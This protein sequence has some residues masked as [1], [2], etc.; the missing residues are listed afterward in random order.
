MNSELFSSFN[1]FKLFLKKKLRKLHI[2][3]FV[4][5]KTK[6][7]CTKN[8][9]WADKLAK[10]INHFAVTK[11]IVYDIHCNIHINDNKYLWHICEKLKSFYLK[12]SSDLQS[13]VLLI[14]ETAEMKIHYL[15][16]TCIPAAITKVRKR[17]RTALSQIRKNAQ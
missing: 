7:W 16:R 8:R 14:N 2:I 10:K 4:M 6:N 17:Q 5:V 12:C 11:K 15:K 9:N 1:H 3:Q 13:S